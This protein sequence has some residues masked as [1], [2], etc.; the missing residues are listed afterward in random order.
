MSGRNYDSNVYVMVGKIPTVV[1]TRTGFYSKEIIETIKKFIDPTE[2]K[3]ILLTHEHY[4]HVG[5]ALDIL[6]SCREIQS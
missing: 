1:D 3:Q 2:I 5:G 4:D 6:K